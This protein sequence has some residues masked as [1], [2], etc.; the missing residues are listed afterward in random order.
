M[1]R[2]KKIGRIIIILLILVAGFLIYHY[3]QTWP[4]RFHS[5]LNDFFGK[6]NWENVS[7]ETKESK[8]YSVYHRSHNVLL[9]G[10]EP[11][12]YHNWDIVFTNRYGEE[13]LWTI[14]DHTLKINHDRHWLFSSERYSA[15]QAMTLELMD[16][17]SSA[18]GEQ[19]KREVLNG[20]LSQE[21]LECLDIY[22][23][24][25]NGNPPPEFYS[26]LRKEPWF[27]VNQATA[28]NYLKTDLYDFYLRILAF[29]YRVEKL[30]EEQQQHLLESLG[31]MEKALLA[32]YGEY[33]DYEIYLGEGYTAEFTGDKARP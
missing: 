31:E 22:I 23:S 30:T 17:S 3:F 28:D 14:T 15:R 2:L 25:R 7:S 1:K 19:V 6:G 27:E 18:A 5:D 4:L 20:V 24:Y 32:A 21:E 12:R 8:M 33:A 9:S 11:G 10:E 26:R 16:V 13:E 29:D